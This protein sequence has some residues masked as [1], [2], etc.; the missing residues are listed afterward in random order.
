[1]DRATLVNAKSTISHCPPS[2]ITR[3][4]ASVSL[5]YSDTLR[6]KLHRFDFLCIC[7]NKSTKWSLGLT[8]YVCAKNR[9]VTVLCVAVCCKYRWQRLLPGDFTCVQ[10]AVGDFA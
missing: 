7:G 9:Q 10:C 2:L 8:V 3:Q 1:M 5:T 4:Q 6:L